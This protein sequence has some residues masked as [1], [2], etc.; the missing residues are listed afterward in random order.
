MTKRFIPAVALLCTVCLV[1]S[2]LGQ[3]YWLYDTAPLRNLDEETNLGPDEHIVSS[4]ERIVNQTVTRER[5]CV[6]RNPETGELVYRPVE[7]CYQN[8][9]EEVSPPDAPEGETPPLPPTSV[10]PPSD[11][12]NPDEVPPVSLVTPSPGDEEQPSDE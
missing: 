5:V 6:L 8:G 3:E 12:D 4:S 7:D 1:S 2:V 10:T 9:A 11:P